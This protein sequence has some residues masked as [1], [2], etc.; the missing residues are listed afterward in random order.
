MGCTG[1][2]HHFPFLPDELRLKTDNR[3]W[4]LG[5]YKGIVWKGNNKFLYLGMQDQFYTFNM[6]D[7]QAWY[8]RDIILGKIK[9]HSQAE[10]DAD[11]QAWR[12]REEKNETD[13]DMIYFQ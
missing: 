8:A 11:A 6:F 13:K 5:L 10:Q 7:A 1:Y 12:D 4:P 3:L 2:Q 9:L